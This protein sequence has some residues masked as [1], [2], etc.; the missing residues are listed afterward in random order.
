MKTNPFRLHWVHRELI[1]N[2]SKR[3]IESKYKGSLFG[4]SWILFHHLSLIAIYTFVF[5]FILK[6]KISTNQ[7]VIGTDFALWLYCGLLPWLALNETITTSV[8]DVISKVNY[9]KKIVFPLEIFPIVTS[10]VSLFNMLIGLIMLILGLVVLGNGLHWSIVYLPLI[11]PALH[12]LGSG[13][14]FILSSLGVYFRDLGQIIGLVSTVWLYATPVLYTEEMIPEKYMWIF[15]LNPL[16]KVVTYFRD[17]LFWGNNPDLLFL[18]E[19]S[20]FS[21]VIYFIGFVIFHKLK[22]GFADVL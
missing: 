17:T 11:L 9:V 16:T 14:G 19:F 6:T 12:F 3:D 4:K 13:I 10:I 5:S 2:F 1:N 15:N 7:G 8:R 21:L 22:K 20:L 18:L